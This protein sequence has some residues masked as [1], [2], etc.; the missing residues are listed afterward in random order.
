MRTEEFR[1]TSARRLARPPARR[2]LRPQHEHRRRRNRFFVIESARPP[3]TV[4]RTV[5]I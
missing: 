3:A 2:R 4:P 1:D 5:D